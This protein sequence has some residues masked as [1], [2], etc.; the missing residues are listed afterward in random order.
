MLTYRILLPGLF[1]AFT[2][3]FTQLK[4]HKLPEICLH[5]STNTIPA[6]KNV[7]M[8]TLIIISLKIPTINLTL[9]NLKYL[10]GTA[11]N[12]TKLSILETLSIEKLLFFC[13][14]P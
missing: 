5:D 10:V 6:L 2:N 3:L 8:R 11:R 12:Q 14:R 1:K 13:A 4:K 7:K 9:P